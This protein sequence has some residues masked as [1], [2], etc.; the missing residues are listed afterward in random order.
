V[1]GSKAIIRTHV[2]VGLTRFLIEHVGTTVS[3]KLYHA[4]EKISL[5]G[6]DIAVLAD[7]RDV[8]IEF[9][10]AQEVAQFA[11]TC[12]REVERLRNLDLV[13][14]AIL[15]QAQNTPLQRRLA[16]ERRLCMGRP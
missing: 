14:R 16:L 7:A 1:H 3:V 13:E 5:F 12:G 15:E 4:C 2:E 10:L 9:H 11:A 8:A 6:N